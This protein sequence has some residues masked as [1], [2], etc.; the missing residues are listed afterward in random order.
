[1]SYATINNDPVFKHVDNIYTDRLRQ[2]IDPGGAYAA[3][4]LPRFYDRERVDDEEHILL[5]HHAVP[6]MGRPLFRDLIPNLEDSDWLPAHKGDTFGPSWT[7]HWF[8][9]TINV[10]Q[11]WLPNQVLLNWDCGNEGLVY[12]PDG[13]PL[14]AFTGGGERTDFIIPPKWC[15]GK[16]TFYIETSCNGMFGNGNGVVDP[17]NPNRYFRLLNADL[18]LPNL[19]A[20]DLHIDFWEIGDLA[21]EMPG[22]LWQKHKARVVGNEIMNTF[23]AHDAD[24][25]I[26]KATDLAATYVGKDAHTE[27]VYENTDLSTVDVFGVGNC[28]IDTAWLWP[29][30]ET[31]RKV[32]RSWITQ[33]DLLDRY[34]EYVF[35]ASQMQQFHWLKQDLPIG[36]EKVKKHIKTGR[37]IPIGGSWVEND[38]NMPCGESLGRQFL[39]GQQFMEHNFGFHSDTFWLPDTFGYL[40]QIPQICRLSHMD[41]FLT[42]KLSWNNINLFPLTTFNWVALDGSQVLSHMPPDNTYTAD[43]NWGDVKRSL[44]Q[45]KN[46]A[47]DLKGLLLFG[48]GDGG[49]GPSPEQI[50]KLRRV[51]GIAN[52]VGEVPKVHLGAT[53][54]DFYDTVL[55]DSDGGKKLPAWN[56]ELYFEFHRGTYTTQA[57]VKKFMRWAETNLRDLEFLGTLASLF[58]RG[59]SY[60]KKELLSFWEDTLLCQFHD[61]L[62]GLCIEMVYKDVHPMLLAVINKSHELILEALKALGISDKS[63]VLSL[64]EAACGAFSLLNTL[65]WHRSGV[66]RIPKCSGSSRYM[67]KGLKNDYVYVST[68]DSTRVMRPKLSKIKYPV[69]SN[70]TEDDIVLENG[71][72]RIVISK[73]TGVITSLFDIAE[74]KEVLDIKTGANKTGANQ[75]VLLNDTPLGWS[76]WDTELFSLEKIV[77]LQPEL[78]R[79]HES[80]PLK[81]LVKVVITIPKS[82]TTNDASKIVSYIS[83]A[84]AHLEKDL[85]YVL[86]ENKVVW[87]EN[88]RFLKVEFPVDI[89]NDYASYET[90]FGITKRPTHYNTLWDV[91]KFEV[92]HH[93]FADY[94]EHNYGVSILNDS[95][96]GFLTHGNLMRLSLLRSSKAPDEHADMDT[97]FFK[98][99]IFPHKGPL[100]ADTVKLGYELNTRLMPAY[101]NDG[102]YEM[103]TTS[104][105]SGKPAQEIVERGFAP[106]LI[107][108]GIDEFTESYLDFITLEG[109]ENVVLSNIKRYELDADAFIN[110]A[111]E[112]KSDEARIGKS[113][114][115][116]V[117]LRIYESLGGKSRAVIKV[118]KLL[119][120]VG[121]YK[122]NN[123]EET[124]EE[125]DFKDEDDY[126]VEIELRAF[127]I[128]GYRFEFE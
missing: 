56:G 18:V 32:M 110:Y 90:Q 77:P 21:R 127:E 28:H 17:P 109:A 121:A 82:N 84:G 124:I 57:K 70:E 120:L 36:F 48:H 58:K 51:R 59:Y 112:V 43:A 25:T 12:S 37:F 98:Y 72:L 78:V 128:G 68:A 11:K 83:L 107:A 14:Q 38:T 9:V 117:V 19:P 115:K 44:A 4:N 105:G 111:P 94:S 123:L 74:K 22:D 96:Y 27:K 93:K 118:K 53:V 50:D 35:V 95:K 3:F 100:G 108:S 63:S 102:V 106:E 8:K 20:R 49:G 73:K 45:H 104:D 97:H 40:S 75:F 65:P 122:V 116:S 34:P 87:N 62:P 91:A 1:M 10:P 88:C 60:P 64:E 99:A 42:Q 13:E 113:S 16:F 5:L 126:E 33:V 47:Y 24:K 26:A 41:R 67:Q 81:T 69:T 76:A 80:G 31:R 85:S 71:K 29:F 46:L 52:T 119:K 55:K 79:I 101:H 92:C 86:V 103:K 54:K 89:H 23:D 114:T 30:A 66:V 15:K 61:V 125:L 6:D 7:T 39:K 2:F